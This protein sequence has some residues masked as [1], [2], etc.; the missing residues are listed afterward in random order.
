MKQEVKDIVVQA[1]VQ[2][3]TAGWALI[4]K[5][6]LAEWLAIGMFAVQVAYLMRKWWREET[7]WG[8]K[9]KRLLGSKPIPLD[10]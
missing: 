1:A 8:L 9:L 10:D 6:T 3:P 4:T 2:A 5:V 7:E